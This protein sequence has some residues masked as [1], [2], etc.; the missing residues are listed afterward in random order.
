MADALH[1]SVDLDGL[2]C[3]H[4]IHGLPAPDA[5]AADVALR[6]WVPRFLELFAELGVRATFF[7][8]GTDLRRELD[9]EGPGVAILREALRCGHELANHS[10][11]H[12]YDMVRDDDG[13]L[14]ADLQRCDAALR[15]L[16]A[17]PLGFRAPGYTHDG[18]MLAAVAATGHL[19]D[20][21]ALPSWSYYAAKAA[22]IAWHRVHGRRSQSMLRGA[23][24]FLGP[25]RP[26]V[27]RESGLVELPITVCGPLRLPL[28]GT[29]LLSGP[30]WV[31]SVLGRAAGRPGA[32]LEL[33]AM[34]LG[35]PGDPGV[36]PVLARMQPELRT[37][38]SV[39]RE[40]LA[41]FLRAGSDY[42]TLCDAAV[43]MRP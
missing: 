31:R 29:F 43:R 8:I 18:R 1:V 27:H 2:G 16:G 37:P 11:A 7:V 40:R 35:D 9:V 4:A 24:S 20:S 3:Y 39:R 15:E 36:S 32:H 28:V 38:L 17:D 19:Y 21:S 26:H 12:A 22:A 25:R 33:H 34:D 30:A 42:Q 10:H 23:G 14:R 5:A 6:C 13:A 41:A